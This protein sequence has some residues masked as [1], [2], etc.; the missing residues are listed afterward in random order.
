MSGPPTFR[1]TLGTCCKDYPSRST[2]AGI[3]RVLRSAL[4]NA[5]REELISKNVTALTTLPSA[6]KT[7]KK[8]Q[9]VVWGVEEA[10]R[11]LEHLRA[12]DVGLAWDV[13][14]RTIRPLRQ[15][16]RSRLVR[17]A[18]I[19]EPRSPPEAHE[20]ARQVV[21]SGNDHGG[22]QERGKQQ[23]AQDDHCAEGLVGEPEID[24]SVGDAGEGGLGCFIG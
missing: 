7:R 21:K 22:D 10:R 15:P 2:I 14:D 3:R 1:R 11:F 20:T 4:G 6:S 23:G 24:L 8:R 16:P 12:V 9:R 19:P 13:T 17:L 18:I 5:V